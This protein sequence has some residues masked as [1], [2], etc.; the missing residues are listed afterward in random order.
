MVEVLGGQPDAV[1]GQHPAVEDPGVGQHRRGR[2]AVL[3]GESDT[4]LLGLGQ[5][6]VEQ[7]V[8]LPGGG[9]DGDQAR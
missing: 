2:A 4:L 8:E 6:D 9:G 3:G 1:G 5:M 7:G